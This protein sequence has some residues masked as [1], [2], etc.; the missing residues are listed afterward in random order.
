MNDLN[1]VD[2]Y[3]IIN[4]DKKIYTWRRRNPVKQGR[5][6]YILMSEN[7]TNITQNSVIKSG[8]RS[9]HSIAVIDLKFNS[10]ERGR[11]LWKFTSNLLHDKDY[12][13]I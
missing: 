2:Y 1:L 13:D 8:Y 7:F 5:L 11:G 4:P 9:D 6:D 3:R 12:I 10:F